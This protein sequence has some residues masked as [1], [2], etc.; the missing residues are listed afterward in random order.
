MHR[1]Q[2]IVLV[3]ALIGISHGYADDRL[4]IVIIMADDLG[5]GAVNCFGT[6]VKKRIW[7]QNIPNEQKA[8]L[9]TWRP[10]KSK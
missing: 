7:P 1:G 4:N 8:C 5:Y 9:P 3:F 6:T 2:A 10:R